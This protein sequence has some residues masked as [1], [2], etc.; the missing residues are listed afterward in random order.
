MDKLNDF[1]KLM[2][3]NKKFIGGNFTEIDRQVLAALRVWNTYTDGLTGR[4][5]R[6]KVNVYL[7]GIADGELKDR[8]NEIKGQIVDQDEDTSKTNTIIRKTIRDLE[9]KEAAAATSA[10]TSAAVSSVSSSSSATGGPSAAVTGIGGPS[11]PPP[12][13]P[14]PPP[15]ST[16]TTTTGATATEQTAAAAAARAREA[17]AAAAREA[18]AAAAAARASEEKEKLRQEIINFLNTT[19]E[20][21]LRAQLSNLKIELKKFNFEN[22]VAISQY[23]DNELVKAR[24]RDE[25]ARDSTRCRT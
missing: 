3:K 23:L 12:S 6:N 20:S 25:E 10:A 5:N 7:G 16:T 14:P 4:G 19:T 1:I 9:A 15:S 24:S 18:A 2:K 13:G 8:L 11:G 17:E 21:N 22:D